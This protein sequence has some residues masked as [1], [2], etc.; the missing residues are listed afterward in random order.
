[1]GTTR[2]VPERKFFPGERKAS[3]LSQE[4][5]T[6]RIQGVGSVR[7]S[8]RLE[9]SQRPRS[10]RGPT[11]PPPGGGSLPG[12]RGTEWRLPPDHWAPGFTEAAAERKAR[13]RAGKQSLL[14]SKKHEVVA[15][16]L[17]LS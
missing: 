9:L 6:E 2:T 1:M 15:A 16:L 12:C 11:H 17:S 4:P 7:T 8:P 13:G 5:P 3:S 10:S 14:Q